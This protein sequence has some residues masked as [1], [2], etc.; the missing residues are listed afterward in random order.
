MKDFA[1]GTR[2]LNIENRW[3]PPPD[4]MSKDE[5]RAWLAYL[6]PVWGSKAL[7]KVLAL[8]TGVRSKV[9][10]ASWIYPTEQVR[11]SHVLKRIISGELILVD[12]KAV[13]APY[14]KALVGPLRGWFDMK[15]GR[16]RYESGFPQPQL[17]S[18]KSLLDNPP[19]R[20]GC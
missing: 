20:K 13:I 16:I 6:L 19:K 11:L 5:I 1:P 12:G 10:G 9:T 3:I 2:R 15:A 8:R 4:V 18:F 7:T 14:P 17:P